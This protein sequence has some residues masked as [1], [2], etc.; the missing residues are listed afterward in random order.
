MLYMFH[1]R[2]R[3]VRP[4]RKCARHLLTA[5]ALVLSGCAVSG[6]QVLAPYQLAD[7][8]RFQ[9]VVTIGADR[10]GT[11]PVVTHVKTFRVGE[12]GGAALVTD[13]IGSGSGLG[14]VITGAAVAGVTGGVTGGL[15]AN[16]VRHHS[17]SSSPAISCSDPANAQTPT[18]L[19]LA[20]PRLPGCENALQ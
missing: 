3:N 6:T 14:A 18:C 4:T 17:N 1:S 2:F 15:I 20:N 12:K 8:T 7:G 10:T 19:C 11:A 5:S 9:D 16:A 13:G